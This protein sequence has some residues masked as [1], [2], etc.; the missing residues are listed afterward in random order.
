MVGLFDG[1]LKDKE[2]QHCSAALVAVQSK[3]EYQRIKDVIS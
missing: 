1:E 2:L 3:E